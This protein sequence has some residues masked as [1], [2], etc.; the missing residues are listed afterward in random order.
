MKRGRRGHLWVIERFEILQAYVRVKH[1][2]EHVRWGCAP[3]MRRPS[4]HSDCWCSQH[5]INRSPH[6]RQTAGLMLRTES[7]LQ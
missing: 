6:T 1:A 2:R 4:P 7:V 3:C 5:R